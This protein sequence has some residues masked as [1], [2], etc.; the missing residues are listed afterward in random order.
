MSSNSSYRKRVRRLRA[1]SFHPVLRLLTRA[2]N[3]ERVP[4]VRLNRD[5][6]LPIFSG[7]VL[8]P[9]EYLILDNE[10]TSINSY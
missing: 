6:S 8:P 10:V 1:L 9:E 3:G 5:K 7:Y 2:L 4:V